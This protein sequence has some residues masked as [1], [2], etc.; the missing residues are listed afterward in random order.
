MYNIHQNDTLLDE[1]HKLIKLAENV[2]E[3]RS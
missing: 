3:K 2:L 1:N